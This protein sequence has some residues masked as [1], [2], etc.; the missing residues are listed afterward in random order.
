M[1]LGVLAYNFRRVT[2]I[3]HS[4]YAGCSGCALR[5]GRF[6]LLFASPQK[7]APL[8]RGVCS[9]ALTGK[10]FLHSLCGRPFLLARPFLP[11]ADTFSVKKGGVDDI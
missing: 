5:E 7:N 8:V 2:N 10:S 3:L 6:F 1:A 9:I 4:G 11:E